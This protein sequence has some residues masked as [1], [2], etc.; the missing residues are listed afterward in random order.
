M[1][2]LVYVKVAAL[3]GCRRVK[4]CQGVAWPETAAQRDQLIVL[5]TACD[6]C[7]HWAVRRSWL[8]QVSVLHD[9]HVGDRGIAQWLERRTRD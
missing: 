2:Q 3:L 1:V 6:M 5:N 4:S 8:A 7:T 9:L